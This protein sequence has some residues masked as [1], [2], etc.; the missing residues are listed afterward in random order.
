[1]GVECWEDVPEAEEHGRDPGGVH[2][3]H[4]ARQLHVVADL[5]MS[6]QRQVEGKQIDASKNQAADA[7]TL[8]PGERLRLAA[9]E[10]AVVDQDEIGGLRERLPEGGSR[11]APASA[12]AAVH[13]AVVARQRAAVGQQQVEPG[14]HP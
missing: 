9:P 2:P 6:I 14:D 3:V 1:M 11:E 12:R 13:E 10:V 5:G 4:A 7:P 8:D